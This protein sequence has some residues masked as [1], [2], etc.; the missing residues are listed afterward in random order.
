[1][2]IYTSARNIF[3]FTLL[4]FTLLHTIITQNYCTVEPVGHSG[5]LLIGL[6]NPHPHNKHPRLQTI[7]HTVVLDYY[8]LRTVE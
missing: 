4:Y 1:M 5:R 7:G 2:L 8:T 6:A 3:Y